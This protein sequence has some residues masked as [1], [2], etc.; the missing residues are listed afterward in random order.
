MFRRNRASNQSSRARIISA[1]VRR[2]LG[3]GSNGDKLASHAAVDPR[4]LSRPDYIRE[5]SLPF[6]RAST[7][8]ILTRVLSFL[9]TL[10]NFGQDCDSF[11]PCV[12]CFGNPVFVIGNN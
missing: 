8:I 10:E 1:T 5:I 12:S 3:T 4:E 6:R 9:L 7:F 11:I 2:D